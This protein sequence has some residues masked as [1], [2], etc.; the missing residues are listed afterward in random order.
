MST[1]DEDRV[2]SET[3]ETSDEAAT[4]TEPKRKL[5]LD[6]QI[7]DAGPCK[8]HLKVAI[9][10]SEVDRQFEETL[11]TVKKEAAVPGFRPGRA[12]RTLVQK[13]FRKQVP[14]Q[15]KSPLLMSRLEQ[16]D[17]DYKIKPT[18]NPTLDM[19]TISTPDE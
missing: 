5:D 7:T 14:A 17:E 10:R 19:E 13:R 18:T 16:P 6:V 9:A 15:V 3:D 11:G 2:A 4:A 8:K 12:P 1:Q